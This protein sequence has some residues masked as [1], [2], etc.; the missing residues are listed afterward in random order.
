MKVLIMKEEGVKHSRVPQNKTIDK[1]LKNTIDGM[2][3]IWTRK[4]GYFILTFDLNKEEDEEGFLDPMWESKGELVEKGIEEL[5]GLFNRGSNRGMP[6]TMGLK[7]NIIGERADDNMV[8]S[9]SNVLYID[10]AGIGEPFGH[11]YLG[12]V[13][14]KQTSVTI[15]SKRLDGQ[16]IKEWAKEIEE[17]SP[18]CHV[19]Q[20]DINMMKKPVHEEEAKIILNLAPDICLKHDVRMVK[21]DNLNLKDKTGF[22]QKM[23]QS[24]KCPVEM[25]K[26]F[27]GPGGI[28]AKRAY[29]LEFGQEIA[30]VVGSNNCSGKTQEIKNFLLQNAGKIDLIEKNYGIYVKE[31][32]AKS[33]INRL[34]RRIDVQTHK[35]DYKTKV[36]VTIESKFWL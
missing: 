8:T 25:K 32:V 10:E 29:N 34:T 33:L 18:Y 36:E 31:N 27:D 16:K 3:P 30:D 5:I 23:E 1:E 14:L 21:I 4:D 17:E 24:C 12:F 2:N 20:L 11:G 15:D 26:H 9:L 28:M 19:E 6:R 35:K 7:V 22:L 13:I